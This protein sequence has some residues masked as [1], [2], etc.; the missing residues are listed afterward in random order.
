VLSFGLVAWLNFSFVLGMAGLYSLVRLARGGD[1]K[2]WELWK[3]NLPAAVWVGGFYVAADRAP[4]E[5]VRVK[6]VLGLGTMAVATLALV[7]LVLAELGLI[8]R[9]R[10]AVHLGVPWIE[11]TGTEAR[12][13]V[14]K[15]AGVAVHL[16][17]VARLLGVEEERGASHDSN[18]H[19]FTPPWAD[20]TAAKVVLE[21]SGEEVSLILATAGDDPKE[22]Q[23]RSIIR[24]WEV[25][26]DGSRGEVGTGYAWDRVALADRPPRIVLEV[27]VFAEAPPGEVWLPW[28]CPPPIRRMIAIQGVG[29]GGMNAQ[30]LP[31][32]P[33]LPPRSA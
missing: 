15:D 19:G 27:M 21:G 13:V 12:L 8:P 10:K 22:P 23:R 17:S 1:W 3:A 24:L 7:Y 2:D 31:E 6:H 14:R 4:G 25:Q 32:P 18:A 9:P 29:G 5:A 16:R 33:S 28:R 26:P 11:N 20:R 30:L